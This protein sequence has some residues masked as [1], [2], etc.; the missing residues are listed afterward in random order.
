M[1]R[2][3]RFSRTAF[4]PRPVR[5]ATRSSGWIPS[6]ASCPAVQPAPG[7]ALGS[8]A[9]SSAT[10]Q[11]TTV[12]PGDGAVPGRY[13]VTITPPPAPEAGERGQKPR[14][15]KPALDQRYQ[16]L[17]QTDLVATVGAESNV[18]QLKVKRAG[19]AKP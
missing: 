9:R 3:H 11:L 7:P 12:Q 14:R 6:R 18:I 5:A 4:S 13:K 15:F 8:W 19:S 10:F 16:S 17:E 2:L 1:P